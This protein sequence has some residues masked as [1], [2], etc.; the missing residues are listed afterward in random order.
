MLQGVQNNLINYVYFKI[1]IFKL[2]TQYMNF[3]LVKIVRWCKNFPGKNIRYKNRRLIFGPLIIQVHRVFLRG[4][5]LI[6]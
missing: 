3:G 1:L 4:K 6:L 5:M 2:N